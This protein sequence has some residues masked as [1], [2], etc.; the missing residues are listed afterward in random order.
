MSAQ[1]IVFMYGTKGGVGKST[2]SVNT[3]YALQQ[4]GARVGLIDLDLSGPNVPHLISGLEGAAPTMRGFRIEPGTYAGVRVSSL[5]FFVPP[6]DVGYLTGRYLE[7]ALQQLLFHDAWDDCDYLVVDLPPGFQ[8]LH[9][10]TFT[11][12]Q[13]AMVLITTPHLLSTQDLARG[14]QLLEHIG[15]PALGVVENMSHVVCEHCGRDSR[16]FE[17]PF[18]GAHEDLP[19]LARVPF[20]Q[21][22]QDPDKGLVPLVMLDD[23]QVSGFKSAVSELTRHLTA[24]VCHG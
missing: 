1:Q 11:R 16:L 14:R 13:G 23:P 6:R 15:V 22:Q 4:S 12:L 19:L 24:E 2:V 18:A 3:A 9:R 8:E 7:G 17:L 21:F 20:A 5:G 10:Q